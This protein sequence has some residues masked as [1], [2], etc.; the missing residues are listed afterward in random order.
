MFLNVT[1][2][3]ILTSI[4]SSNLHR[5]PSLNYGTLRYHIRMKTSNIHN[6]GSVLSPVTFSAQN[7]LSRPVSCYAFFKGWLLPSLPPS[8]LGR[9][10]SFYT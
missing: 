3:S 6:F 8:C 4:L 5:L 7:N 9:F 1:H 2:V 10:T